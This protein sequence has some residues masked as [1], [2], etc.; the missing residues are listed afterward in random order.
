[1]MR[2]FLRQ[3][4]WVGIG[5]YFIFSAIEELKHGSISNFLHL[6]WILAGLGFL[7]IVSFRLLPPDDRARE[8]GMK[9]R[10]KLFIILPTL[11]TTALVWWGSSEFGSLWRILLSLYGGVATLTILLI[12]FDE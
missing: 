5:T 4:F 8:D 9:A 12:L 2:W 1:M 3:C 10:S 7:G 6:S 11:L